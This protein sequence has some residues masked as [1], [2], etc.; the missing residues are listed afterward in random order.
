MNKNDPD[1]EL[2]D[3]FL[4]VAEQDFQPSDAL[5]ARV[6]ADA[7]ATQTCAVLRPVRHQRVRRWNWRVWRDSFG[8]WAVIGPAIAA[9]LTGVWVG[10]A[11]PTVIDVWL[12]KVTGTT[13]TLSFLYDTEV[14]LYE[15]LTDG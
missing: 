3:L 8:G 11:S 15:E 5:V 4:Q 1:R 12:A 7:D 14:L 10:F 13:Q 6:L 2:D 9:G